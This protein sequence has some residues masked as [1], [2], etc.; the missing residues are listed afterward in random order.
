LEASK[1]IEIPDMK[2]IYINV[3]GECGA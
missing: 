2:V 1:I 3:T